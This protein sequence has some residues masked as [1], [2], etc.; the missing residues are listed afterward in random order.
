M[1]EIKVWK[2]RKGGKQETQGRKYFIML[3]GRKVRKEIYFSP[4]FR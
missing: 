1:G 4:D 2:C 3:Q